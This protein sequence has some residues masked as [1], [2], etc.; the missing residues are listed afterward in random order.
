M[1]LGGGG[2]CFAVTAGVRGV[3]L[4]FFCCLGPH[5]PF[6]RLPVC[7]GFSCRALVGERGGVFVAVAAGGG[8]CIFAVTARANPKTPK[9]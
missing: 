4:L 9:P 3:F 2:C 7:W 8:V 6:P 1:L 5:R